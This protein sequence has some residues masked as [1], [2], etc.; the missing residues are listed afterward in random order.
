VL[1][2]ARAHGVQVVVDS[3]LIGVVEE[4][5]DHRCAHPELIGVQSQFGEEVGQRTH[6]SNGSSEKIQPTVAALTL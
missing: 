2:E 5:T 4:W 3:A 1:F 6:G